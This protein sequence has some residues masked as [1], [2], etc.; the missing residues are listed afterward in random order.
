MKKRATSLI[1]ILCL[2]LSILPVGLGYSVS[3]AEPVELIA[4]GEAGTV[5]ATA[6][7]QTRRTGEA[8]PAGTGG[9]V[10]RA[11]WIQELVKA[12]D[13]TVEEAHA[14][15]NY[16]SDLT[17]EESFYRDILVAVQ[18]GI[19]DIPA[20]EA[21]YPQNAATREFA[22]QTLNSCLGFLHD[23]SE[24]YTFSESGTVAYPDAIQI[25][26]D[27]GWFALSG[28]SFLP[29]QAI[30]GAEKTAMLTDAA[31][32]LESRTIDT[33]YENTYTFEK[34]VIEIPR[35][36][37]VEILQGVVTIESC[38][39][40]LKSGDVFVVWYQSVP[41]AFVANA[42]TTA[43]TTT[44]VKATAITDGSAVTDADAQG[45]L[46]AE[47]AQFV[48]DEGTE[49]VY[50]DEA[51]GDEYSDAGEAD[52]AIA[53]HQAT[54]GTRKLKALQLKKTVKLGGD[55]SITVSARIKNPVLTYKF[56]IRNRTA[57][58]VLKA[59]YEMS[60]TASAD[61]TNQLLGVKEIVFGFW[62][63]P[64]VGG[65][66][67]AARYDVGGSV[68]G[69][70]SG[71]L[72]IGAEYQRGSG[73]SIPREF[74][75]KG[76]SFVIE[77][78]MK[79]GIWI[80]LGINDVPAN[81]LVGNVAAEFG[82]NGSVSV[83]NNTDHQAPKVCVH[84]AIYLYLNMDVNLSYNFGVKSDDF[85]R[86]E[87]IWTESTSPV[88]VVHHY[89]DGKEVGIC[90]RSHS[91]GGGG[92]T[93][94]YYTPGTSNYWNSGW[95]GGIGGTAYD[96]HG[97]PIPIYEYTVSDGAAT[98]TKYN[99]VGTSVVIPR[100]ID[101]YTIVAIGGNAFSHN[102]R[103]EAVSIPDTV[104]VLKEFAFSGCTAL[105]T[106][107]L[108]D[109][110][111]E[112]DY[113]AF[114][115]CKSLNWIRLP[116]HIKRLGGAV[117]TGCDSLK[118]IFIPKSLK[119]AETY[120]NF[121]CGPF[122]DSGLERVTFE[123]GTTAVAANLFRGAKKLKS[124]TLL[125]T[126]TSIGDHAFD[127]CAA[128]R[129]IQIPDSVTELGA[130]AFQFC[131]SLN[132]ITLPDSISA[133][134]E[135]T[136]H[137][138][139]ALEELALPDSVREIG[140]HAFS[141]CEKLR[142][143]KLPARLKQL[144]GTAFTGCKN[145][146]SI[147]IPKSL[148][149]AGTYT[150]YRYG[151]FYGSGLET[152]TFEEGTTAVA[153]NL[154]RGAD[155]LKAVTLTDT[156]TAIGANA[157]E[158]CT[159]LQEIQIPDSVTS[160]GGYAF[161]DSGLRSF[162]LPSSVTEL[163]GN[164]FERCTALTEFTWDSP[165][166]QLPPFTFCGCT[167]LTAFEI[168]NAVTSV[169]ACAFYGCSSLAK[170]TGGQRVASLGENAF[171]ECKA[172]KEIA[173][174]PALTTIGTKAFSLCTALENI[175]IPDG[176]EKLGAYSFAGCTALKSVV[177]P[178]NVLELG[179]YCF[180][181]C[182]ALK[183]V[184]LGSGLMVIPD[185]A[186]SNCG[187]LES[188]V[189]PYR[190]QRVG[191]Y[192]F[193]NDGKLRSVTVPRGTTAIE[194]S[195]FSYPGR[196]TIY[197][198]SGTYAE[199]F[200]VQIGAT[201]AAISKPATA[202][203][204]RKT[205][206]QLG[207]NALERLVVTITPADFTDEVTWT[208]SDPSVAVVNDAGLVQAVGVGQSTITVTAGTVSAKCTVTVSEQHAHSYTAKVTA[209]TCTERGYTTHT[210]TCGDSY[211]D[212]YT[213]ALGHDWGAPSYVW[214][215]NNGTVTATRVCKRDGSHVETEKGAITS[216]VTK[217]ATYEAE[218]EITY[219]ATFTN[220]AFTTQTKTAAT[221]KLG[222][223]APAENPFT[224]VRSGQYY[225]DPV[226][227]AVANEVTSGTSATTF[228]PDNG[229]TRAQV[230]TFLWRAAGQ[231]KPTTDSNPF[232]DVKNGTYY[233]DAVLWAVEQGITA[234]TSTTTFS[235]DDTCT[236][237][238]IVT[239]LWRF[240]GQPTPVSAAN[241]FADVRL[242]AYFGKAVLWAVENGITNGTS[243]TTFSPEATCTR[244]QVVTFLYRDML[245]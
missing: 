233:Y 238:Q 13:M 60:V 142:S 80:S 168:P 182:S 57:S 76:F 24:G 119:T 16:F 129:E 52:R 133:I 86:H 201:F 159:A 237:A 117:F 183:E 217:E 243:A 106:V 112:L 84:T 87:M 154:F 63:C 64:G 25:A 39:K 2:L 164:V 227:W 73:F 240:E 62:G 104:T 15:D 19:V 6:F 162:R 192:A 41:C 68:S 45:I 114:S 101:G 118:S 5:Q 187:A 165:V 194:E 175:V 102:Q 226:L 109:S 134:K 9:T 212:A 166:Q 229:C 81:M 205:E 55:Q 44:T 125:E 113:H 150:D 140:F 96:A 155:Q 88:R 126:M 241:P 121:N 54:R 170:V 244:A 92:G 78:K 197:G 69:I 206:L 181:G 156:M 100:T 199:T 95:G 90:T 157:F 42:V 203:T 85:S 12:F 202:V 49:V 40:T 46:D 29:T 178:D 234:G 171:Y 71:S 38:P 153:A 176:V 14:P 239:F 116:K 10:T 158:G 59:D 3:A 220:A 131:T 20:G 177:I 74:K 36:A 77:A 28:G 209:P 72:C 82:V 23:S 148:E 65:I 231:P 235:P 110:V 152:A 94:K 215:A 70:Y 4:F 174:S 128:L 195:A 149:S 136:F 242:S 191:Y 79:A 221:P 47:F 210:C 198:V 124:V 75:S 144:G 108:P 141:Y 17:G 120:A 143:V 204:L 32:V 67:L 111:T 193:K 103:L 145:L 56:S 135:Y 123:E 185:Y 31:T 208:S 190:I 245:S 97:K 147:C 180:D 218:G 107:N 138:C 146:K 132:A 161:R 11:Q 188:L 34:N 30:T 167:A 61:W 200:A 216:K 207:R 223:P 151:A 189:L 163:G 105:E 222:K 27:R 18:F 173:L 130:F 196:L 50:V 51:T 213:D 230:V 66:K 179:V 99:G 214:A 48:P 236:R 98:L 224:D 7:P 169:G 127:G 83:N 22:A 1:L 219:T 43:G 35:G 21:F 232:R 33:G 186:F 53:A 211:V 58:V 228:S 225:Y 91:G 37:D 115:E 122:Y 184:R 8:L 26:I 93:G 160:I 139:D 172:L 89:E 137:G